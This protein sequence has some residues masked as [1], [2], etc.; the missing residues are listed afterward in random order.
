M[1]DI[2]WLTNDC[3]N[4]I[5][6]EYQSLSGG[7][8]ILSDIKCSFFGHRK[9]EITE[10]LKQKV[11]EVVEDLI[12]NHNVLTFLFG[13]R[14][15][16]DYLC[17]LVVTELK[18]KYPNIIRKCYTCRSETCTLESERAHWE[19]VYSHFR[20]EKVTLLGVEE[21][22]EHKTKYTSGRA[23][24]VERNQA[25]INDSD[26]CVFYYDENYQPEM[27]KYSKRSIGYY[28]PKSGTALAYAYA[29]QKKKNIYNI[30]I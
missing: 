27:R 8:Y 26:Y 18:E 17:H 24:Y 12:I 14:S 28:Q 10:E 19:E 4:H 7:F 5:M 30:I 2:V 13:S 11:K 1:S 29:K 23:S 20:K 15:D 16:F 6:I 3:K 25:M 9:I 21:E 22:V